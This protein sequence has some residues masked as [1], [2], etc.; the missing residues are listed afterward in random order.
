MTSTLSL[1]T[2]KKY[3]EVDIFFFEQWWCP[4]T[5]AGEASTNISHSVMHRVGKKSASKLDFKIFSRLINS[6][7][8]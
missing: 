8:M 1:I 5:E 3:L 2:K 6:K 7:A 4:R